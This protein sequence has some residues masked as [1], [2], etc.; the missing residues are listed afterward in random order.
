MAIIE[1]LEEG[2]FKMENYRCKNEAV[3]RQNIG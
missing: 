2:R 3:N 1:N